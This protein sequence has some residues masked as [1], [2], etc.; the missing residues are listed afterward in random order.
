MATLS[1]KRQVDRIILI[2][3]DL[4][5]IP[6][7]KLARREGVQVAIVQVIGKRISPELI[8]DSDIV[9]EVKLAV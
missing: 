8:E 5:M 9:R 7:M 1:L 4:D 3:G 6:A 2:S